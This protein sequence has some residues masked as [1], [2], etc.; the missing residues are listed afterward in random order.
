MVGEVDDGVSVSL[1]R[2]FVAEAELCL[3]TGESK[4]A[5]VSIRV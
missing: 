1:T 2:T 4:R 5:L 3:I